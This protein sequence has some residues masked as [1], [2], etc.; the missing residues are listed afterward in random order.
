MARR[1]FLAAGRPKRGS[2]PKHGEWPRSRFTTGMFAAFAHRNFRLLWTGTVVTQNGQWMQQ[3]ALGWLILE[4]TNS[5]TFLGLVGFARGVPMLFLALPAGVLADRVSRRK[6]LMNAQGAAA[7]VA[8]VLTL[9]VF[10]DVVRPWQDR[11]SV[12]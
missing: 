3:V 5:P 10:A 6:I 9:I 4:I 11:K 12:V 7:V 1:G 2:A 8:L